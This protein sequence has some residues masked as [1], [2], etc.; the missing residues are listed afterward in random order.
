MY[1]YIY[2]LI[3]IYA[4]YS[5][6]IYYYVIICEKILFIKNGSAFRVEQKIKLKP[7][8]KLMNKWSLV[9]NS[10]IGVID[11]ETY[12]ANDDTIKIY[13]LGFKTILDKEPIVYY[14]DK[15][16]MNHEKLV[17]K[18][19]NELLR[20]KYNKIR[21]YYHNLGGYDIVFILKILYIFNEKTT[22]D[23]DKYKIYL[24]L[25]E[26]RMLKCVISKNKNNLVLM[27]SYPILPKNLAD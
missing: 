26:N 4:L 3:C 6:Y 14:I 7:L 2:K 18:L 25:K 15:T 27:D 5:Y 1:I 11:T 9:E 16:D 21:F 12:K 22:K 13:A 17:L 10:N 20:S 23:S 8:P 19:V 24:T